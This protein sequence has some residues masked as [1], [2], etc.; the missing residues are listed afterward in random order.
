MVCFWEV[1]TNKVD[2]SLER[3]MSAHE[4]RQ[5]HRV[6]FENDQFM[7][8]DN[9]GEPRF[10]DFW[11][12]DFV[13]YDIYYGA[14]IGFG[15]LKSDGS[16]EGLAVYG[17]HELPVRGGTAE[18]IGW[19]AVLTLETAE[20]PAIDTYPNGYASMLSAVRKIGLDPNVDEFN[21]E[22]DWCHHGQ[23]IE[24][25]SGISFDGLGVLTSCYITEV[26]PADPLILNLRVIKWFEP[27]HRFGPELPDELI[28]R[29]VFDG[30]RARIN[31]R[32]AKPRDFRPHDYDFIYFWESIATAWERSDSSKNLLAQ[33]RNKT[34]RLN[35]S[36]CLGATESKSASE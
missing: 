4:I 24:E 8:I 15:F 3:L 30:L 19:N 16:Y 2:I 32:T 1:S 25:G 33:I 31:L 28:K 10:C 36:N 26:D 17:Q 14:E 5:N 13:I 6:I 21:Y 23:E 11:S 12:A 35:I 7:V 18:E 34:I 29:P 22:I 9:R 20:R 27:N